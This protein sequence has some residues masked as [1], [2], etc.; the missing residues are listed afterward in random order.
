[1]NNR[2]L[3]PG[4]DYAIGVHTIAHVEKV[5]YIWE[6]PRN[7]VTADLAFPSAPSQPGVSGKSTF[8]HSD[9]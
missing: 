1:M 5:K 3:T 4:W 9:F 2:P 7:H 8:D 6:S